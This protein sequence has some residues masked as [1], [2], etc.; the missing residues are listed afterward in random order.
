LFDDQGRDVGFD[1][2]GADAD[3]NHGDDEACGVGGGAC[4][5]DGGGDEDELTDGVDECEDDDGLVTAKVLIRD[6]C[7]E[8]GS[9]VA[10]ELV[11]KDSKGM[12]GGTRIERS[13]RDRLR[14]VGQDR[15]NP[16]G[17][18][19]DHSECNSGM[20]EIIHSK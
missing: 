16:W 9:D 6:N 3:D 12:C 18:R 1:A 4:R 20:E 8:D 13:C 5:G 11:R 14:L 19:W 7:T 15:D 10:P 17:H 2:S